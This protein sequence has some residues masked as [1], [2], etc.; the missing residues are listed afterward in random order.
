MQH[1]PSEFDAQHLHAKAKTEVG[2]L[3]L[4]RE[5]CRANLAL[6]AAI[7]E[8][9]WHDDPVQAFEHALP[10]LVGLFQLLRIDPTDDRLAVVRPGGV[11]NRLT[12]RDVRV[13][14]LD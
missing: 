12:H 9:T 7:A 2:D 6:D 14:E 5:L 3:A 8:P 1:E 4:S 13:L 11:I 10:V